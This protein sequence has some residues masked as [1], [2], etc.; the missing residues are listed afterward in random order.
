[1]T[2]TPYVA[3][4]DTATT[5]APDWE[6]VHVL[7]S[8]LHQ[9]TNLPKLSDIGADALAQLEVINLGCRQRNKERAA[10]LAKAVAEA[11][12][13]ADAAAAALAA[14]EAAAEAKQKADAETAAAA[15]AATALAN[16]KA[17]PAAKVGA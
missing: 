1:M 15:K 5:A 9:T 3:V 16:A 8:V 2:D 11:K 14:E 4:T 17:I 13:K 10:A 7:L 12:A 6:A